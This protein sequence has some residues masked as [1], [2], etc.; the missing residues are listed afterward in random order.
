MPDGVV[1]N[2]RESAIGCD[3]LQQPVAVIVE[4]LCG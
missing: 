2:L 1:V 4:I 3:R